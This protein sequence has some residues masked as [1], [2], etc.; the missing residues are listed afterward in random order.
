MLVEALFACK[1]RSATSYTS[2]AGRK[3]GSVAATSMPMVVS[4]NLSS[5]TATTMN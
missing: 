4:W 3:P 5:L 1:V 2:S